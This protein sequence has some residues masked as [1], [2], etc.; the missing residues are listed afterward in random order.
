[1]LQTAR[2]FR[3]VANA[4]A[5]WNSHKTCML[6]FMLTLESNTHRIHVWYIYLREWLISMVNVGKYTSPMDA[7]GYNIS[8]IITYL[9]Q[10][11]WSLKF[12]KGDL[13]GPL[14]LTFLTVANLCFRY[15]VTTN[16]NTTFKTKLYCWWFRNPKNHLA[17]NKPCKQWDKLATSTWFSRRI[18]EPS[19][20]TIG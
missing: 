7:I 15:F 4:L 2:F 13:K 9:T 6:I 10:T 16:W 8:T 5:F 3:C 19:T 14:E 18:S 1:M 11:T 12:M 20:V 17:C